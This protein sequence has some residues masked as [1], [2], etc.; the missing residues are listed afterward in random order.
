MTAAGGPG[1]YAAPSSPATNIAS[2]R[3]APPHRAGVKVTIPSTGFVIRGTRSGVLL[4]WHHRDYVHDNGIQITWKPGGGW[5]FTNH[6][7]T[8]LHR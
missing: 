4:C 2:S 3:G 7:D 6:H 5:Q 1:S 8:T